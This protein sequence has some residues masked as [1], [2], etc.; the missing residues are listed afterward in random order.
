MDEERYI[1]IS[2]D[3]AREWYNIGGKLRELALSVF[4]EQELCPP[5]YD[6]IIKRA[7]NMY[8]LTV[9]QNEFN[10]VLLNCAT[11]CNTK[12]KYNGEAYFI[13]GL[14]NI[15]KG[16]TWK[17]TNTTIQK[18]VLVEWSKHT[19][20]RYPGI[21]YFNNLQDLKEIISHLYKIYNLEEVLKV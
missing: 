3:I 19:T 2:S 12:S 10:A 4:T 13:V 16:K 14:S 5:N 9:E 21:A 6:N 17:I 1:K 7:Q 20:V 11:I 18:S 15:P 8:K